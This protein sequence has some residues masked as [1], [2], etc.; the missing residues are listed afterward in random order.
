LYLRRFTAFIHQTS[1]NV[2]LLAPL[3][4]RFIDVEAWYSEILN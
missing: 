2:Y 4:G 1:H 3:L